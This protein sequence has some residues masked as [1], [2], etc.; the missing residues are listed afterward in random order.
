VS[1]VSRIEGFAV[2]AL[3]RSVLRGLRL[4]RHGERPSILTTS[5]GR[6]DELTHVMLDH[7]YDPGGIRNRR[8]DLIDGVCP[9]AVP[10]T[11]M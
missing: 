10:S 11:A 4:L 2:Y 5:W 1:H 8:C 7:V 9:M 6:F 3:G